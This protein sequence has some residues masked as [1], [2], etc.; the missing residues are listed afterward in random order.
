MIAPAV[1]CVN[2]L[3]SVIF[4]VVEVFFAVRLEKDVFVLVVFVFYLDVAVV[5]VTLVFVSELGEGVIVIAAV[6]MEVNF[7]RW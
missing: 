5:V 4:V 7:C 1:A 6:A 2:V 3:S